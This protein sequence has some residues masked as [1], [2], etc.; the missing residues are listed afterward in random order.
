MGLHPRRHNAI[1]IEDGN[2]GIG[3]LTISIVDEGIASM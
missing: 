1:P 2:L 3:V